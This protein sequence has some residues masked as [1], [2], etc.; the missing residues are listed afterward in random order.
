MLPLTIAVRF[1]FLV[2]IFSHLLTL[3]KNTHS[4]KQLLVEATSTS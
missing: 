4:S 1:G 3:L 2:S